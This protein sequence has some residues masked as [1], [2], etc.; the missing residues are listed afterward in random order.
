M[1]KAFSVQFL[2]IITI[3]KYLV[4]KD[5]SLKKVSDDF[6]SIFVQM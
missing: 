1:I 5:L 4:L 6:S 3:W 2:Q